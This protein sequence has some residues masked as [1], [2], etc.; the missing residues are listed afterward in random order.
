MLQG[1]G[2]GRFRSSERRAVGYNRRL[3]GSEL[4]GGPL[5]RRRAVAMTRPRKAAG[6]VASDTSVEEDEM[7]EDRSDHG[8]A[9]ERRAE[10]RGSRCRTSIAPNT[11]MAPVKYM[12]HSPK[13]IRQR[14]SASRSPAWARAFHSR[15]FQTGPPRRSGAPNRRH[16][17]DIFRP[18]IF[19]TRESGRMV[20]GWSAEATFNV[21]GHA[22]ALLLATRIPSEALGSPRTP[23]AVPL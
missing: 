10:D 20:I 21:I 15:R 1:Q 2:A 12:N 6:I 7:T 8:R 17:P 4:A 3:T 16:D 11:C 13:P 19:G 9:H 18:G 14:A 5:S 22:S 23:L